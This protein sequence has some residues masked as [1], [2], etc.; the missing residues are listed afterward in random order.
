MLDSVKFLKSWRCFKEGDVI[1]FRPGINLLVGDQGC[2]KSSLLTV[3]NNDGV[4]D[5]DKI[6]SLD[7]PAGTITYYLDFEKGSIRGMEFQT[8]QLKG[9]D[10]QAVLA[11]MWCSHGESVNAILRSMPSK[12]DAIIFND[13]PDMALS[14][15][16][17]KKLF[18]LMTEHVAEY[19]QQIIVSCHNPYLMELVGDV[20]S[21]EHRTWMNYSDFKTAMQEQ[22]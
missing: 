13:E 3:L 10:I 22:V 16:S 17:I 5:K 12:K 8:A 11:N 9:I 20:Y 6:A 4:I 18:N 2:G 7:A 14:I 19:N 15:R 21:L 1:D